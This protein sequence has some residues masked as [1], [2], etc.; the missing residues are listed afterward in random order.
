[1]TPGRRGDGRYRFTTVKLLSE[2]GHR[3][4]SGL[5]GAGSVAGEVRPWT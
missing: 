3:E 4:T 1:M 5:L 2:M